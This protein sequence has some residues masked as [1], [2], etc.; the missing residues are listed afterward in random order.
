MACH[1]VGAPHTACRSRSPQDVELYLTRKEVNDGFNVVAR[2][3]KQ[4]RE[5]HISTDLSRDEM[6][7]TLRRVIKRVMQLSS[8]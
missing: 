2:I 8:M 4:L 5:L 1:P 6:K 3:G 7:A